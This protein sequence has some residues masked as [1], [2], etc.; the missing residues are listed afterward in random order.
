MFKT[1]GTIEY[2]GKAVARIGADGTVMNLESNKPEPITVSDNKVTL[3]QGISIELAADGTMKF[4]GGNAASDK[5]PRVEGADTPGKRR[6]VLAL[7][8]LMIGGER[9]V[10]TH[11]E[12]GSGNTVV[13]VPAQ[14]QP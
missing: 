8:G 6:T 12:E 9:Q 3:D 5:A 13:P 4:V 1:D 11:V 10:E 14:V 7:V 2:K